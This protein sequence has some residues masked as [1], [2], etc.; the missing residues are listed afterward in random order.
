MQTPGRCGGII[1]PY[2]GERREA[3]L[4]LSRLSCDLRQTAQ[5]AARRS[6]WS[7]DSFGEGISKLLLMPGIATTS[8]LR[9]VM[10]SYATLTSS[11]HRSSSADGSGSVISSLTRRF[12]AR[13][14]ADRDEPNL[15]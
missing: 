15:A 2:S 14:I 1:T 8:V 4:R 10:R 9:A 13:S 12:V 5:P 11:A 7:S 6:M 3:I